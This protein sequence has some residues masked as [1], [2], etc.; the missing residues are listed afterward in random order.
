MLL[1]C[2]VYRA[3]DADSAQFGQGFQSLDP[4]SRIRVGDS[5]SQIDSDLNFDAVAIRKAMSSLRISTDSSYRFSR[6]IDAALTTLAIHRAVRLLEESAGAEPTGAVCDVY[7]RPRHKRRIEVDPRDIRRSLGMDLGR[8]EMH[9]AL[10]RLGFDTK[11]GA[12]WRR[13]G[14]T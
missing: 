2:I 11:D 1:D 9:S 6:E 8:D 7:P 5:I 12:R 14:N 3:R 13:T 10:R 4:L